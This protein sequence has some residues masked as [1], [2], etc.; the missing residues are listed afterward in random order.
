MPD[1][2]SESRTGSFDPAS[3]SKQPP[4]KRVALVIPHS[5]RTKGA[6][7]CYCLSFV[8]PLPHRRFEDQNNHLDPGFCCALILHRFFLALALNLVFFRP[9]SSGDYD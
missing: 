4:V 1:P 9:A 2:G 7:Q 8:N 6:R 3:R 5:G